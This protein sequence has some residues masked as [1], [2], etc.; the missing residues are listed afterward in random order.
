MAQ[1]FIQINDKFLT[2]EDAPEILLDRG[3]FFGDGVFESFRSCRERI[4]GFSYH[5]ER[6]FEGM[7][8]LRIEAEWTPEEVQDRIRRTVERSRFDDAYVRVMVTRGRWT[9]SIPPFGPSKPNLI[10]VCK[11]FMPFREE[12]YERGFRMITLPARRNETSALCKVK[13]LNYL[14]NI[15]GRLHA[16]ESECDEGLYLNTKG[17]LAEGTASNLFLVQDDKLLTPSVDDGALPGVTRRLIIEC[18][19][20]NGVSVD[21]RSLDASAIF[22]ADEAFLTNSSMGVVPVVQCDGKTIGT[23]K[24]GP[25]SRK[26]RALYEAL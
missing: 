21:Q 19:G 24:P 14:E 13:S 4:R 8:A 18:A 25:V 1:T 22:T 17:C 16:L 5:I 12:L 6:L 9:G 20:K 15:M 10:V 3:L 23:R 11:K 7:G 2:E 26:M